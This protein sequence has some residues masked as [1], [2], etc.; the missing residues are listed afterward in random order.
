MSISKSGYKGEDGAEWVNVNNTSKKY[1]QNTVYNASDFCDLT[2]NNC[3]V[4][5]SVNWVEDVINMSNAYVT[6]PSIDDDN[7]C[8]IY[9]DYS[10]DMSSKT[11][12]VTVKRIDFQKTYYQL[13]VGTHDTDSKTDYISI[14][15]SKLEYKTG[16][17]WKNYFNSND[18]DVGIEGNGSPNSYGRYNL[19]QAETTGGPI[20]SDFKTI[21]ITSSN[22]KNNVID[23][24]ALFHT[25]CLQ[26]GFVGYK[27]KWD[28][29]VQFNLKT[30]NQ[31]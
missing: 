30:G 4:T 13:Y 15:G 27:W 31:L 25:Q 17:I 1:N 6:I 5:L 24:K 12:T 14:G 26:E 18:G 10:Y 16:G 21:T 11:A 20:V 8:R 3:E 28:K 9:F 7:T 19:V 22:I 29:T 23:F 2:S